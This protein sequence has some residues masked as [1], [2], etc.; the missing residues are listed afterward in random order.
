[1][2]WAAFH[3]IAWAS[4]IDEMQPEEVENPEWY[5]ELRTG[6]P[7]RDRD[8]LFFRYDVTIVYN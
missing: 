2:Q 1:M 8:E 6:D 5:P 3:G 4:K 7:L